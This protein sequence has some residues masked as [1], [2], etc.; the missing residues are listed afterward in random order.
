VK[1]QIRIIFWK[2]LNFLIIHLIILY[3]RRSQIIFDLL[4]LQMDLHILNNI[5]TFIKMD[6]PFSHLYLICTLFTTLAFIYLIFRFFLMNSKKILAEQLPN[7]VI[8]P[9]NDNIFG[10]ITEF[11]LTES[12]ENP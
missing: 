3:C 12:Q 5:F 8:E 6:F 1:L 7:E 11:C 9:L 4:L 2:N 10:I